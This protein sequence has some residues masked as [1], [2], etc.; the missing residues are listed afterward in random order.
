[1]EG[2][3]GRSR[4]RGARRLSQARSGVRRLPLA[5]GP[6]P[7]GLRDA[8]IRRLFPWAVGRGLRELRAD[9]RKLAGWRERRRRLVRWREGD[10]QSA[11]CSTRLLPFR[12]SAGETRRAQ[13]E[14]GLLRRRPHGKLRQVDRQ[15]EGLQRRHALERRAWPLRALRGRH[16]L[17]QGRLV[18]A[19]RRPREV[20]RRARRGL[21]P[22]RRP[23][24]RPQSRPGAEP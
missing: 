21:F 17:P 7:G 2:R 4:A 8:G 16:A 14:R 6:P 22:L 23:R 3:Q 11:V 10:T 15:R 20:A 18:L 19:S 12:R 9:H 24:C 5:V 1:M 13:S